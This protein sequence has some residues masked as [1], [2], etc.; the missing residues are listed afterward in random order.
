MGLTF[1]ALLFFQSSSSDSSGLGCCAG[2]IFILVLVI[3]ASVASANSKAKAQAQ[4]KAS[5][6]HS[7]TDLKSDP[8]N[9]DLRQQ[10]LQ[11]GRSYSNLTR[12]KKGVTVFDEV[13]LMNDISA[14]CARAATPIPN[15]EPATA[16]SRGSI[17]ERLSRLAELKVQGLIDEEEYKLRRQRILDEL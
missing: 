5:Y 14:A 1:P 9:A 3:V 2:I 17:E 4:A 13:A 6:D 7:L 8:G 15:A 12:N 16:S 10:T 11:L